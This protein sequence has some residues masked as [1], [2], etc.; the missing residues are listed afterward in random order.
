[1]YV[2]GF[3]PKPILISIFCQTGVRKRSVTNAWHAR[4]PPA[5]KSLFRSRL[6]NLTLSEHDGDQCLSSGHHA[7][8]R[9]T[10]GD[11]QY[12]LPEPMDIDDESKSKVG[13]MDGDGDVDMDVPTITVQPPSDD[14]D[15]HSMKVDC[16]HT[17]MI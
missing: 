13:G 2:V 4:N 9:N 10:A 6:S 3:C 1:M 17:W 15:E 16:N 11:A 5:I 8:L 12:V 7:K 14:D